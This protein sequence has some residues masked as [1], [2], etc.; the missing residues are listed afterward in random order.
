[1]ARHR[2]AIRI[3]YPPAV[4]G[5]REVTACVFGIWAVHRDCGDA[6]WW[7]VTHVPTGMLMLRTRPSS[8]AIRIAKQFAEK[9]PQYGVRYKFGRV[10][11]RYTESD[12]AV[13][14]FLR[15]IAP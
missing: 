12:R 5:T 8:Q 13:K 9:F 11:W 3:A 14:E 7:D 1:M 15:E 10:R 2:Q 4:G 6:R